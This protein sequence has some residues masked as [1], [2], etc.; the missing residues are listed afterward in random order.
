MSF[1]PKIR[2]ARASDAQRICELVNYYAERGLMLHRSLESVYEHLRDFIV[3]QDETG[4]VVGCVAVSVFWS[5]LAEVRSIA[6]DPERTR[7]GIGT[8][9]VKAAIASAAELGITRIFTLTYEE[10]FFA[11]QG[12][13]AIDR[14]E[15]PEKVWRVCISCPK[16][17]ACDEIAMMLKL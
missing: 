2:T 8:G 7:S 1:S 6:I 14:Q 11:R 15:L 17:D 4:G 9:L 16:A 5:D 3:A 12:F 10:D 13:E